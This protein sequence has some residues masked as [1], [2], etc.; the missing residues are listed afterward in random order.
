MNINNTARQLLEQAVRKI[1]TSLSAASANAAAAALK[2]PAP[3]NEQRKAGD[4]AGYTYQPDGTLLG[5]RSEI[6]DRL[7]NEP[8]AGSFDIN[9]DRLYAQYRDMYTKNAALAAEN[10]FGL[11][12]AKTGGYGSSYAASAASAAYGKY[13]EGLTEKALEI[14]EAS[15][16]QAEAER[17]QLTG[18]LNVLNALE[19]EDYNRFQ[20]SLSLAF[21]A[22]KQGDY[23]LLEAKGIDTASLKDQ[24][25]LERAATAAKYGDYSYLNAL[26]VD[27]SSLTN[28]AA[29]ERAMSAAKY[30]DYSYLNALGVDTSSLTNQAALERAMSAAKY[31]D[32]SYLNALGVDTSSLTN[33]AAL[34]RAVTAAR[35]GDYSYLSALGIDTASMQYESLLRT[36]ASLAQYGDYSGLEALGVD[37]SAL[38]EKDQLEKAVTLAKYGDYSLLGTF[39]DNLKNMKQKVSVTVQNGAEAAYAAG[40]YEALITYLDKQIGYGQINEETKKQIVYVLTGRQ[41]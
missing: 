41:L 13:M 23:S 4:P 3:Q 7:M 15:R 25:A 19:K 14:E 1:N 20:D 35:Y 9:T 6:L 12:S 40:G 8:A 10:A 18:Q 11:A 36:A 22:A 26:G 29:L 17:A 16:K 2:A 21:N 37:V 32:Y 30:G 28:Q 31:G 39:S 27:T 38:K 34:E 24:A 5:L 33:Q